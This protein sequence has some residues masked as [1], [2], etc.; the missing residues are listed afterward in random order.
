M[1]G[2]AASIAV[3]TAQFALAIGRHSSINDV[4]LNAAGACL[5]GQ[6]SQH[7]W[8]S[9]AFT[10]RSEPA[11]PGEPTGASSPS[12][13]ASASRPSPSRE[14]IE[15]CVAAGSM[16]TIHDELPRSTDPQSRPIPLDARKCNGRSVRSSGRDELDSLIFQSCRMATSNR[17]PPVI[18]R[19]SERATV[20]AA[21]AGAYTVNMQSVLAALRPEVE[22]AGSASACCRQH[23]PYLS[24]TRAG[25]R[26]RVFDSLARFVGTD[27]QQISQ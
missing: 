7:L 9:R 4:L 11:L 15:T 19:I 22:A 16:P 1:A 6:L 23:P 13:T 27:P 12:E 14:I 26:S 24:G 17:P 18:Q 21:R 3:E 10:D 2:A 25:L 5:A 8:A 20:D